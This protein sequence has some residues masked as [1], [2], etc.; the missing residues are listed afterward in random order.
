MLSTNAGGQRNVSE[1]LRAAHQNMS[2]RTCD[3]HMQAH[4]YT[5]LCHT[6]WELSNPSHRFLERHGR[7]CIMASDGG[8]STATNTGSNS[9]M[10]LADAM[11]GDSHR[12]HL[13]RIV[14][15]AG[16]SLTT[17]PHRRRRW[18]H[19]VRRNRLIVVSAL[20]TKK[21]SIRS[22]TATLLFGGPSAGGTGGI[23]E[24]V[25]ASPLRL[26][27]RSKTRHPWHL[28][29]VEAFNTFSATCQAISASAVATLATTTAP[30][31]PMT[32]T[33]RVVHACEA[34][35]AQTVE[36]VL[37]SYLR[38]DI[39]AIRLVLASNTKM[40]IADATLASPP[41]PAHE[42]SA[43]ESA[44]DACGAPQ[45]S[46]PSPAHEPS[47][48]ES[49]LD[50]CGA[51]QASLPSPAHEP[52]AQEPSS[53]PVTR[54]GGRGRKGPAG[55]LA[56]DLR[57]RGVHIDDARRAILNLGLGLSRGRVSQL[58]AGWPASVP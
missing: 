51:P 20:F 27:M 22:R 48:Q 7:P 34:K 35:H 58:L 6:I 57:A 54:G 31:T 11:L 5:H 8:A 16:R 23:A 56:A 18:R 37:N 43:Q 50:A 21:L 45:A 29:C 4:I 53:P 30:P 47:A 55:L 39:S 3:G 32:R 46:L 41:S 38:G 15:V 19:S 33:A 25:S 52:S 1:I 49:A 44:P 36:R 26:T 13:E 10:L 28:A 24:A 2:T 12:K 40:T 17:P 42:P 14:V 9:N